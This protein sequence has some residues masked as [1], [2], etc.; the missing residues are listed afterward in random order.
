MWKDHNSETSVPQQVLMKCW[1]RS[2]LWQDWRN[3]GKSKKCHDEA[4]ESF[5]NKNDL[6]EKI[7][8]DSSDSESHS[9]KRKVMIRRMIQIMLRKASW[10]RLTNKKKEK[11]QTKSTRC[12]GWNATTRR[13][14][15]KCEIILL[16][17]CELEEL[18]KDHLKTM[19]SF[20][21]SLRT[22]LKFL[23]F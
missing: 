16:K 10:I 17:S 23:W 21:L 2:K 9:L 11:F 1:T 14:I 18:L 6:H 20:F 4:K 15:Q 22:K 12:C 3:D 7:G 13:M 5:V 19:K 8:K